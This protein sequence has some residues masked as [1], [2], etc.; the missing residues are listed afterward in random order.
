[1]LGKNNYVEKQQKIS[2]LQPHFSIRKLTVGAASVLIG[3]SLYFGNNV[4]L[5]K[6][7]SS[8]PAQNIEQTNN[9]SEDN[10]LVTNKQD[11]QKNEEVDQ[12]QTSASQQ[13][14]DA[15]ANSAE[16]S[17]VKQN[18]A[19]KRSSFA[20]ENK[21]EENKNKLSL[22]NSEQ[23]TFDLSKVKDEVPQNKANELKELS[24]EKAGSGSASYN[25]DEDHGKT[26]DDEADGIK[27]SV[28]KN[29]Y[30]PADS[31]SEVI[32]LSVGGVAGRQTVQAGDKITIKIPLGN[33]QLGDYDS[34]DKKY[35]TTT[36]HKYFEEDANGN[37]YC[38]I[39]DNFT[40]A[41]QTITQNIDLDPF[42]QPMEGKDAKWNKNMSQWFNK[43][44]TVE[45]EI[46]GGR[47]AS[48]SFKQ[49][50]K[51]TIDLQMYR[52]KP[53]PGP[54]LLVNHDYT[55]QLTVNEQANMY[56]E[57]TI[58]YSNQTLITPTFNSSINEQATIVVQVPD[59]FVLNT[60]AT[61]QANNGRDCPVTVSQAGKGKKVI[62]TIR[63]GNENDSDL[64]EKPYYLVGKFE[65]SKPAIDQTVTFNASTDQ[66]LL[67]NLGE[68]TD[69]TSW[70]D[71]ILGERNSSGKLN[72]DNHPKA[73]DISGQIYGYQTNNKIPL[74][75]NHKVVLNHISFENDNN[76]DLTDAAVTINIPSG[77]NATGFDIPP[78][79]GNTNYKYEVTLANGHI[80]TGYCT[81]N[82]N[83]QIHGGDK[84]T[85]YESPN[86]SSAIRKIVVSGLNIPIGEGTSPV[87]PTGHTVHDDIND[88][89]VSVNEGGIDIY[90]TVAENYDDGTPVKLGDQFTS[91][92]SLTAK[93]LDHDVIG[94][95]IQTTDKI[96]AIKQ[97]A[98]IEYE[99]NNPGPGQ[100]MVGWISAYY[101]G[102]NKNS[103]F[104]FVVPKNAIY[105][106]WGNQKGISE[107]QANGHTVVKVTYAAES[108]TLWFDNTKPA[109]ASIEP[110]VVYLVTG[111]D[112]NHEVI[113]LDA[114]Q[115]HLFP[116]VDAKD[117]AL[118]EGNKDAYLISL[119]T[120]PP[121]HPTTKYYWKIMPITGS[122]AVEAAEGNK[123]NSVPVLNGKS[124]DHGNVSMT[125][126]NQIVNTSQSGLTNVISV[127]NLP[128]TGFQFKLN[129]NG[130]KVLDKLG[131]ELNADILYSLNS[132][133]LD[134]P[135]NLSDFV[136]GNQ[137]QNKDW[138]KVKSVA[139]KLNSLG[140][141]SFV[142]VIMHGSDPTL[143][144]DAGKKACLTSRLQANELG[145]PFIINEGNK[146]AATIGI[147]GQ[148][149]VKSRL[150]YK[151]D[152]G[153]DQYIDL[154][155]KHTYQDN[156]DTMKRSDFNLRDV[157]RAKIPTGYHLSNAD[158]TIINS[159][160]KKYASGYPNDVAAFG[161]L[162]KY[163]FDGDIVQYELIKDGTEEKY[164]WTVK[165]HDEQGNSLISDFTVGTDY[166]GTDSYDVTTIGDH[167]KTEIT[168]GTDT[169][170]LEPDKTKN[171]NGNFD[172][173]NQTTILVYKLDNKDQKYK[174]TV[175]YH[176]ENG[177][178]LQ[179]DVTVGTDYKGTDAY[180]VTTIGD[181]YKTEITV[182]DNTYSLDTSQTQNGS[183]NF[184]NSNQTTI[185][186]Y[187]LKSV[188]PPP[189]TNPQPTPSTPIPTPTTPNPTSSKPTKPTEPK[190]PNQSSKPRKPSVT[191]PTK[192]GNKPR[193]TTYKPTRKS[194]N[195]NYRPRGERQKHDDRQFTINNIPKGQKLPKDTTIEPN[196]HVVDQNGRIIGYID[197]HGQFHYS[198]P[199]TDEKQ[200][201]TNL[202]SVIGL[203]LAG[204]GLLLGY[205]F[206]RKRNNK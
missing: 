172:N 169:Y 150:H 19:P 81:R 77:F 4:N 192:P 1:M 142:D 120:Y 113:D 36:G 24:E 58:Y 128:Q 121:D 181:N 180:D 151:D 153:H 173:K 170:S 166:K 72:D 10:S 33:Y 37:W 103:I 34:L 187:K 149:T 202:L 198:L 163:Y 116:K 168:V 82:D 188:T 201:Q 174:W 79:A 74:D 7:D 55:W 95:V 40:K 147:V 66:K 91:S 57:G 32:T 44:K 133:D 185:L 111:Q 199:Q 105:H 206:E 47:K 6:A 184:N 178:K 152:Q 146:A 43:T 21:V 75:H 29:V 160:V 63:H 16:K 164:N 156:Q 98:R 99:Q 28:N 124:D 119:N 109:L 115:D 45:V 204:I 94:S 54:S 106:P 13:S 158:P 69:N 117:L 123:D 186:V 87:T 126:Y 110:I 83:V 112:N 26:V 127:S 14:T 17:L 39:T 189:T 154:D 157:D 53:K 25:Y 100:S 182:G 90:G 108:Q 71:I 46:T 176:D 138:S 129:K 89:D 50:I 78:I 203:T 167:Y 144:V 130:V 132:V 60:T 12:G 145:E 48:I 191:K 140:S 125:F 93:D 183:G 159:D 42:Y 193:K 88:V 196:G 30:N 27:L 96:P 134:Q 101:E 102:R 161:K 104:Y 5:V 3:M 2:K 76:Q 18:T 80:E 148:S 65:M 62:F 136:S 67:Y 20:K 195:Y 56:N 8:A 22:S 137:L 73:E 122:G 131:N 118:V 155:L 23:Q 179:D 9:K 92:F 197:R 52:D 49:L 38:T 61:E 68:L 177:H 139:V 114:S 84:T 31:H 165:Y 64:D 15:K 86:F 35:G 97:K 141:D 41:A 194:Y 200:N 59:S 162:A 107:F 135:I 175:E 85:M 190:K 70:Q 51:P 205:E 143:P 171:G 11:A